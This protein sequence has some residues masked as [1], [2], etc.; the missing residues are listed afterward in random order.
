MKRGEKKQKRKTEDQAKKSSI[1]KTGNLK[2]E[3]RENKEEEIKE[4][5]KISKI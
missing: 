4:F 5:K 1:W 3:N 2:K